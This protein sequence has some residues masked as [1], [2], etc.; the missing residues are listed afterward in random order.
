LAPAAAIGRPALISFA[1]FTQAHYL[2]TTNDVPA[3]LLAD[4]RAAGVHVSLCGQH[5]TQIPVDKPD[6][7]KYRIAFANLN[8]QQEFAVTVNDQAA[9]V[10][11]IRIQAP[12]ALCATRATRP[13]YR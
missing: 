5:L 8:E 3:A 13:A 9:S 2:I 10:Q 1:S 11:S 4:L 6:G 7:H 12:S